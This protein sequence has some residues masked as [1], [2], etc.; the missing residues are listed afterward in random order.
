MPYHII[1]DIDVILE[2]L[3]RNQYEQIMKDT[4]NATQKTYKD[5]I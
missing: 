2:A 4:S 5:I 1:K 3:T